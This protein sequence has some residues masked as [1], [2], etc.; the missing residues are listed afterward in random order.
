MQQVVS[1][2]DRLFAAL[3]TS[4]KQGPNCVTGFESDCKAG[5]AW[6]VIR[7]EFDDGRLSASVRHQG[8]VSVQGENVFFPSIAVND[9]GR[10]AIAFALSG[11]DFFPSS[12][13]AR[14][15]SD[16]V[17]PVKIAA[18]GVAPEDGFSGYAF[19]GGNGSARWGD[20]TAAVADGDQIVFA[21][22]FIPG[23]RRLLLANWG[24]SL[25]MSRSMEKMTTSDRPGLSKKTTNK[26]V[27]KRAAKSGP[28][29]VQE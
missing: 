13:F 11:A 24:R 14:F 18:A 26:T 9:E 22:E 19:F 15:T 29:I 27:R 28:F 20:Y 25:V 3:T 10:G 5:V 2:G 6:F 16:E 7:P 12:A 8:Y 21:T 17:G 4:V 23:G 1:A